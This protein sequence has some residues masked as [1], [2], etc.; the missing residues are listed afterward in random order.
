MVDVVAAILQNDKKEILIAKRKQGKSQG[1][2]WEFPGGKVEPGEKPE[3]SL[4][5]ELREE[6]NIEVEVGQYF[7]ENIHHYENIIIKLIAFR[8]RIVSG[9]IDLI[10]HDDYVWVDAEELNKYNFAPA[11]I[12]LVER[13]LIK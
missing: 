1:G 5:R 9:K 8:G 2:L 6:M 11:D 7:G 13:L 4:A 10:D 12:P 3:E